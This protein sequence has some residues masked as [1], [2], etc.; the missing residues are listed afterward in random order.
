MFNTSGLKQNLQGVFYL[1]CA[2][3]DVN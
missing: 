1:F 3:T 2:M